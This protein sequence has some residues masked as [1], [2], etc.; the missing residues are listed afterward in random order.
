MTRKIFAN[1]AAM[2]GAAVLGL[3]W[4][5]FRRRRRNSARPN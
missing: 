1:V 3:T 4:V 2:A 5:L